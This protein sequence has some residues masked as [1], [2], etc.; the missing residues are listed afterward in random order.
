MQQRERDTD[1]SSSL[2]EGGRD[3]SVQAFTCSV[4]ERAAA[5]SCRVGWAR[6]HP[7]TLTQD[8]HLLSRVL[9]NVSMSPLFWLKHNLIYSR[10]RKELLFFGSL[11]T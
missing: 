9:T 1:A 8:A 11:P 7:G 4:P 6:T 10:G 5:G 2:Q 3:A